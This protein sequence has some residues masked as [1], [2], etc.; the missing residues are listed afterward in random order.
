MPQQPAG[1]QREARC[2]GGHPVTREHRA[3]LGWGCKT[4]STEGGRVNALPRDERGDM[5]ERAYGVILVFIVGMVIL[6]DVVLMLV[7]VW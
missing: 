4:S 1:L 2:G 6:S 5:R 3:V 7:V